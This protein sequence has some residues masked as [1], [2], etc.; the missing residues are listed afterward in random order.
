[1]RY[2]HFFLFIIGLFLSPDAYAL[3]TAQQQATAALMGAHTPLWF[4]ED[5]GDYQPAGLTLNHHAPTQDR[6]LTLRYA[7]KEKKQI[8]H[9]AISHHTRIPRDAQCLPKEK[10]IPYQHPQLGAWNLCSS[11]N[12]HHPKFVIVRAFAREQSAPY[13]QLNFVGPAS[14][15]M[16]LMGK[17]K[18]IPTPTHHWPTSQMLSIATR[19]YPP[20]QQLYWQSKGYAAGDSQLF[21]KDEKS[22]PQWISVYHRA[23]PFYP[24]QVTLHMTTSFHYSPTSQLTRTPQKCSPGQTAS[25]YTHPELG[26]YQ[27]CSKTI[28]TP[29]HPSGTDQTPLVH[30][31]VFARPLIGNKRPHISFH[32]HGLPQ[33][34][35]TLLQQLKL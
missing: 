1:M 17:L 31:V 28:R 7:R 10:V 11:I 3:S 2:R 14:D 34:I 33:E 12:P 5:L 20:S 18:R 30:Q 15:L 23:I 26:P 21:W 19:F 24:Q 6:V 9:L 32:I 25:R 4:I 35:P 13:L 27:L 8:A 29:A 22:S 16:P